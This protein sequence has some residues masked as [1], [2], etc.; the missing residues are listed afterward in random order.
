MNETLDVEEIITSQY[1]GPLGAY[2]IYNMDED[3]NEYSIAIYA[4]QYSA[5][6]GLTY[7]AT[8]L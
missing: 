5:A 2:Y 6:A 3:A 8:M 4:R 7:G 1:T